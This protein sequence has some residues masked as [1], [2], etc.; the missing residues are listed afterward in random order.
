M[1]YAH[2]HKQQRDRNPYLKHIDSAPDTH[3]VIHHHSSVASDGGFGGKA[4]MELYFVGSNWGSVS[5]TDLFLTGIRGRR[6]REREI[7]QSCKDSYY[8]YIG[9]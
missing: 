2:M 9:S 6:K 7:G 3:P 4:P 5:L 8:S 1:V